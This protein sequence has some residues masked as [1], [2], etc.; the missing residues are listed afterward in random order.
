MIPIA[1]FP[2]PL[3]MLQHELTTGGCHVPSRIFSFSGT[4][5]TADAYLCCDSDSHLRCIQTH[6]SV[7]AIYYTSRRYDTLCRS[8]LSLGQF[9]TQFFRTS[10]MDCSRNAGLV[11]WR[12][13][14]AWYTDLSCRFRISRCL[15]GIHTF[16]VD[17]TIYAAH[18]PY[19]GH[20]SWLSVS[21]G[22]SHSFCLRTTPVC[23]PASF[24]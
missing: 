13:L 2:L 1:W 9:F 4:L 6:T 11:L 5:Y 7:S 16:S 19:T 14:S 24:A 18:R 12:L 10:P 20:A 21:H 15:F 23:Q 8:T 3:H 17:R 22:D